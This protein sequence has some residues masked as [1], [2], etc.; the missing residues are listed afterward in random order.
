MLNL[1][2]FRHTKR[3]KYIHQILGTKQT[4]QVIFQGNVELGFTW[5]SLTSGTSTQLIVDT[6]GLMTLGTNDT[7]SAKFLNALSEFDI[8][9]TSGHVRRDCH[10]TGHTGIGNDFCLQLMILRIQDFVLDSTSFQHFAEFFGCL[11]RNRTDENRLLTLVAVCDIFHDRIQF[12]TFCLINRIVVVNTGNRFISRYF[13]NVHSVNFTELFFLG[14]RCTC[15]TAFFVVFIKEVLKRNRCQRPTFSFYFYML[16][17]FDRLMQTVGITASRHNASGKFIYDQHFIIFYHIILVAEH[18]IV[19]TK[20]ENN[21]MLDLKVLRI[22]QVLNMEET[23]YLFNTLRGKIYR[24][25][26]FVHNK[27]SGLHVIFFHDKI[28]FRKFFC[29]TTF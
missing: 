18:Q 12:F 6:S 22:R 25:F 16:F 2:T 17:C 8:G 26:L 19:R 9:T 14:K 4:H 10:R 3:I 15:H 24:F 21:T 11:D 23:L 20:C 29:C 5:I 13:H 1:L 7:K 28:H 27:I